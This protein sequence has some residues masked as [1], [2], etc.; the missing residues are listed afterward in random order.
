VDDDESVGRAITRLARRLDIE[1]QAFQSGEEFL[2]Q[3]DTAML[4][5]DCL[6]L[7]IQMPGLSGLE[8]QEA[9][10]RRSSTCPVIVMTA[11][12]EADEHLRALAL[13]AVAVLFKPFDEQLFIA[14]VQTALERP[15]PRP[16]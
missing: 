3:L 8:V 9:L 7:D 15:H 10:L 4:R 16:C 11:Y 12:V 2:D 5:P 13:G 14:T 6:L 1:A